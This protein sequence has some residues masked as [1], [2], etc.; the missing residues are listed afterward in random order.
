MFSMFVFT[1]AFFVTGCVG[2][3][4]LSLGKYYAENNAE[5]YIEVLTDYQL[6]FINVDFSDF[7]NSI[8]N[9]CPDLDVNIA[10]LFGERPQKYK[11]LQKDENE[12]ARYCVDISDTGFALNFYCQNG[13]LIFGETKYSLKNELK[14]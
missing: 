13:S 10:E 14:A 1:T 6:R 2:N 4:E 9:D 3:D 11:F 8:H 12:I 7:E 5:S